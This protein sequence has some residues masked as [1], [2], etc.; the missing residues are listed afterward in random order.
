MKR[1]WKVV[2]LLCAFGI[3]LTLPVFAGGNNANLPENYEPTFP[4]T[5]PSSLPVQETLVKGEPV[6]SETPCKHCGGD[7]LRTSY[8]ETDWYTYDYVDCTC[9]GGYSPM[10]DRLVH[11]SSTSVFTCNDCGLS[12]FNTEYLKKQVHYRNADGTVLK[13]M[14]FSLTN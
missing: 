12:E 5:I 11:K 4:E 14:P 1:I 10:L 6:F 13:T 8:D 3:L 7:M 2:S 9:E